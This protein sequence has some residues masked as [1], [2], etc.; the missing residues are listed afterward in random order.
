MFQFPGR[1]LFLGHLLEGFLQ[2][3]PEGGHGGDEGALHSGVWALHGRAEADDVEVR[4][5]AED[6]RALQS[7]MVHLDDAVGAVLLF[8]DAEQQV[9][10]GRVG[11]GV[12][13]AVASRGLDLHASHVEAAGEGVDDVSLHVF[14]AGACENL[15]G[16]A[17]V[18]DVDDGE[19]GAGLHH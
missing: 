5:F 3:F 9:E 14:A 15:D 17:S 6:D 4:I 7:G 13:S 2:Q 18:G 19:V 12:P 10:Q 11:V 8:V 16:S 1:A